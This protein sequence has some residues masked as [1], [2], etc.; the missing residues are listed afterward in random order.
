MEEK[1]EDNGEGRENERVKIQQYRSESHRP[2]S[3]HA[4]D[5]YQVS[6]LICSFL[7]SLSL[8]PN[9]Y[10]NQDQQK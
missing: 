9:I 8:Y 1:N 5:N 6:L 3:N 4:S 7:F 2:L 10:L